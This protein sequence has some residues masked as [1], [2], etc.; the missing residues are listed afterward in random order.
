MSLEAAANAF[1]VL[2]IFFF[3]G[4]GGGGFS[5]LTRMKQDLNETFFFVYRRENCLFLWLC[6]MQS[7]AAKSQPITAD[8]RDIYGAA[9]SVNLISL[10]CVLPF[11]KD[12]WEIMVSSPQ[13]ASYAAEPKG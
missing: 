2:I 6:K 12:N 11:A 9:Q 5:L 8:L 1:G 3:L 10:A 13:K 4:G 7:A